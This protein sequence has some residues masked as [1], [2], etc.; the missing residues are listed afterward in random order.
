M[1]LNSGCIFRI[2]ESIKNCGENMARIR[3]CGVPVFRPFCG[4]VIRM[5]K[6]IM[7]SVMKRPVAY[8]I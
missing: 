6:G 1:I 8:F 2:G 3:L 5:G 7:Y 4:V